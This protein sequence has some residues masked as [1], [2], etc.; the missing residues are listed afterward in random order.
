MFYDRGALKVR[1]KQSL[2]EVR[3]RP[4]KVTLLYLALVWLIPLILEF[5]FPDAS[6]RAA[7][8]ILHDLRMD[9]EGFLAAMEGVE[10]YEIMAQYQELAAPG[11]VMGMAATFV[12]VLVGL[13]KVVMEYGYALYSLRLYRGEETKTGDIFSGLAV[14][15]R[16]IGTAIMTY[17]FTLLWT[18]LAVILG[19]CAT[20][21]VV[22]S[23]MAL[24]SEGMMVLL[25]VLLL[26]LIWVPVIIFSAFIS[27]RYSLAPY[28]ILTSDIGV[29]EA[30]RASKEYMRG[31][32]ARRFVLDL[33]FIGWE[34]L[35]GLIA[36]AVIFLGVF[37]SIFVGSYQLA[38]VEDYNLLVSTILT[39]YLVSFALASLAT[40]PL[41][42]W[43]TPYRASAQG[44]FFLAVTGQEGPAAQ[45]FRPMPQPPRSQAG[46]IWDNVPPPPAFTTPSAPP[47]P[48]AEEKPEAPTEEKPETPVEDKPE[49]PTE[50]EVPVEEKP[51]APVEPEVEAPAENK[52][53]VPVEDSPEPPADG[54]EASTE[55]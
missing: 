21:I 5:I 49:V 37:I 52:T 34:L 1:A 54:S 27:Y 8:A 44:G 40:M 19:V 46:D 26:I 28:L 3:P 22:T 10:Y 17:I 14:A 13:F 32:L 42:L 45:P 7:L 33:S 36:C 31:N 20:L 4:W 15:G 55:E 35:N 18:M 25:G 50:A 30:I 47:E 12:S 24:A 2:R 51:E 6:Q 38:I 39:G 53:E 16:A 43:L 48:P 11:L 9:P 23:L 29:M 41:S